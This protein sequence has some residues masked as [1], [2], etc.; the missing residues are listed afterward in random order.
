ME[1][2]AEDP[3]SMW[4]RVRDSHAETRRWCSV[5]LTQCIATYTRRVA[6]LKPLDA[7]LLSATKTFLIRSQRMGKNKALAL[8]RKCSFVSPGR[9]HGLS[10]RLVF[11]ETDLMLFIYVFIAFKQV[12][13]MMEKIRLL[14][15]ILSHKR[16]QTPG[17]SP[18]ATLV[19]RSIRLKVSTIKC[20]ACKWLLNL[21]SSRAEL[22]NNRNPGC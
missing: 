14:L 13:L 8:S 22:N 11:V 15:R 12:L 17:L 4:R 10:Q 19:F 18:V 5:N 9:K 1:D 21:H 2:T 3:R 7:V 20:Y 6:G 16:D